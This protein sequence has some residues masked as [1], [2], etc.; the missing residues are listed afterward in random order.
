MFRLVYTHSYF[1][2]DFLLFDSETTKILLCAGAFVVIDIILFVGFLVGAMDGDCELD[3]PHELHVTAQFTRAAR[4]KQAPLAKLSIT[5]WQVTGDPLVKGKIP[6]ESLQMDGLE[7]VK[8]VGLLLGVAVGDC[9]IVLHALH[10]TGQLMRAAGAEHT[11]LTTL[12]MT[13]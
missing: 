7:V 13:Y 6:F 9:V 3:A 5:H 1:N 4:V 10:T 8:Y 2:P 11:P 12:S